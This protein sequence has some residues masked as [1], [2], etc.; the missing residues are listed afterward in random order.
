MYR[1]KFGPNGLTD[2]TT[3]S[4]IEIMVM[5][6]SLYVDSWKACDRDRLII[7]YNLT[8]READIICT[9]L[10]LYKKLAKQIYKHN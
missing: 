8:D 1:F 7:E 9:A 6:E 3:A 2:K 10:S 5:A 4:P